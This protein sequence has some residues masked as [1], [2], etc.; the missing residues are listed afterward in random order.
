M[1]T[2]TGA[3]LLNEIMFHRRVEFWGE[4]FR[5]LDLKR[6]NSPLNRNGISNH[7][8]AV[9]GVRDIPAGDPGWQW[10]YPQD[11]LN[12]NKLITQNP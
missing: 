7:L 4:G 11:E 9:I 1:S 8:D 6:T 2:E 12:T 10:V 5:F 3:T